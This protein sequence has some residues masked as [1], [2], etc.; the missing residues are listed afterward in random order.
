MYLRRQIQYLIFT[1]PKH[2]TIELCIKALKVFMPY[3]MIAT[4]AAH[5]TIS[6][7]KAVV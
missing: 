1:P 4:I 6:T 7:L 3:N 5:H 2:N